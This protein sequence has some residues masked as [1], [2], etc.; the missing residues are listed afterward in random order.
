YHCITYRSTPL[1][2]PGLVPPTRV[3]SSLASWTWPPCT[4]THLSDLCVRLV[5]SGMVWVSFYSLYIKFSLFVHCRIEFSRFIVVRCLQ[6]AAF[7]DMLFHPLVFVFEDFHVGC[8]GAQLVRGF[9]CLHTF[10]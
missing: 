10:G 8:L 2:N 7:R 9:C 5:V 6:R 4:T 1:S 3:P